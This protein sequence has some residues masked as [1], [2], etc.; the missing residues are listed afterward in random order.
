MAVD[1]NRHLDKDRSGCRF[2]AL[3]RAVVPFDR[4]AAKC[5][6]NMHNFPEAANNNNANS[7]AKLQKSIRRYYDMKATGIVRRIDC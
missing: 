6:K 3:A 4:M 2:C 1:N 7:A 5:A